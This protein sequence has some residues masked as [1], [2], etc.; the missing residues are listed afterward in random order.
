MVWWF[1]HSIEYFILK[2][3]VAITSCKGRTHNIHKINIALFKGNFNRFLR[4]IFLSNTRK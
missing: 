4:V 1:Y 2:F 3:F